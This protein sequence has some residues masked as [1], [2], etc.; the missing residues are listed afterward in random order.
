M[1]TLLQGYMESIFMISQTTFFQIRTLTI[2]DLILGV[3]WVLLH[4]LSTVL[5]VLKSQWEKAFTSFKSRLIKSVANTQNYHLAR[6]MKTGKVGHSGT[7][8][9]LHK[10]AFPQLEDCKPDKA[11]K[12][13]D[14]HLSLRCTCIL[15]KVVTLPFQALHIIFTTALL[16]MSGKPQNYTMSIMNLKH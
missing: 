15:I 8:G 9:M 13:N 2:S 4:V 5:S 7:D 6:H 11:Q 1:K 10:L 16:P 3:C 12:I 14:Q